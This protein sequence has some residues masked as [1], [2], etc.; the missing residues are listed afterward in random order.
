MQ[1]NFILAMENVL[2][3]DVGKSIMENAWWFVLPKKLFIDFPQR[4]MYK[5]T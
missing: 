1:N 4:F 5:T 3:L 2:R